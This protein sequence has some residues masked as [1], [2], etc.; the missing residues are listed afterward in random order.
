MQLPKL[1]K[2]LLNTLQRPQL[3]YLRYHHL[4]ALNAKLK[5]L[6]KHLLKPL[7]NAKY[8]PLFLPCHLQSQLSAQPKYQPCLLLKQ[9]IALLQLKLYLK[10]ALSFPHLHLKYQQKSRYAISKMTNASRIEPRS[11][12]I[13]L[14]HPKEMLHS[15]LLQNQATNLAILLKRNNVPLRTL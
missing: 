2:H 5:H 7:L 11:I 9:L 14:F 8:Q 6:Q 10:Y 12:D 13:E 15:S 4:K 1:L 3:R